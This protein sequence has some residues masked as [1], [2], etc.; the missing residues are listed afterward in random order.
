SDEL[1]VSRVTKV[2]VPVDECQ[3]E[4]TTATESELI[5]DQHAAV[6]AENHRKEAAIEK[7]LDATCG[8][9]GVALDRPSVAHPV[10]RL[11]DRA[12]PRSDNDTT[13]EGA[14]SVQE[15]GVAQR[16]RQLVHAWGD[17]VLR[18]SQPEVRGSVDHC[19]RTAANSGLR[20]LAA[21]P[22]SPV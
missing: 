4:S 16:S 9:G 10:A 6:A 1:A 22:S 21:A 15:A 17:A 5:A 14:E 8:L 13:I 3:A 12:V 18:G 7:A 20:H 11:P 2:A 19:H